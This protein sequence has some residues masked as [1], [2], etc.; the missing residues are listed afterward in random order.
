[1]TLGLDNPG[2]DVYVSAWMMRRKIMNCSL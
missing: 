2:A 1:M